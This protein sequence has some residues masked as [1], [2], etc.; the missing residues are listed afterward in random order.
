MAT[1]S[2]STGCSRAQTPIT[3][4]HDE[5]L[6]II[7]APDDRALAEAHH[8]RAEGG[9]L[10]ARRGRSRPRREDDGAGR[11]RLPAAH[12]GL[13]RL[14]DADAFRISRIPGQPRQV[15]QASSRTSTG[16]SSSCSATRT[17]SCCDRTRTYPNAWRSSRNSSCSRAS[18]MRRSACWHGAASRSRAH[19]WNATLPNPTRPTGACRTPGSA[20]T[21]RRRS[22]GDLYHL[23]EKLV[24]F[25]HAFR[26]WRFAHLTTVARIIGFKAAGRAG[27]AASAIWRRCSRCGCFRSSGTVRTE[28]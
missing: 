5:P 1:I 2:A 6:F 11:T 26:S 19:I 9:A 4:H 16:P 24:D 7:P 28:L 18:T 25:E 3:G 12:S 17:P 10:G 20:S 13:G 15:L 23:A 27:R 8:P 22:T 14:G 21:A